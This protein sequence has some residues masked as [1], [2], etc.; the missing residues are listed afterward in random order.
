MTDVGVLEVTVHIA[1]QPGTVFPYFTDPARYVS[2]MG[3]EASLEPVPGGTYRVSMRDG[4]EAAGE[5]LEIDPPNHHRTGWEMYLDRLGVR[6]LGGDP[7]RT[8]TRSSQTEAAPD[9]SQR[10]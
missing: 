3:N 8:P 2:W 6:V 9:V 7:A 5:F 4:A 10:Q 1:A